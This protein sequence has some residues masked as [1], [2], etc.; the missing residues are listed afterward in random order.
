MA[1]CGTVAP[2]GKSVLT[3]IVYIGT[4]DENPVVFYEDGV[5]IDLSAVT[6]VVIKLPG[7]TDIDT[8]VTP[9]AVDLSE[10]VDGILIFK[11]ND[12]GIVAG[13]YLS[14]ILVYDPSHTDGQTLASP[15]GAR[16]TFKFV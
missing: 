5:V 8:D 11:L 10:A 13:S 6:R 12:I 9:V 14:T 2:V 15:Y 3:E 4:D 1:S 16:L 7:Q